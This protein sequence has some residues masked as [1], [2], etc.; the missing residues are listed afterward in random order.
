MAKSG[1]VKLEKKLQKTPGLPGFAW[2]GAQYVLHGNIPHGLELLR[3][4][5]DAVLVAL[6]SPPSPGS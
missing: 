4:N 1:V 5:A 2:V 3:T 6:F